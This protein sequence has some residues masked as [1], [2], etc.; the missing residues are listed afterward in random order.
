[1]NTCGS[2]IKKWRW[3]D[4]LGLTAA[5]ALLPSAAI[6]G[7]SDGR[8]EEM[9]SPVTAPTINEDPRITTEVRPMYMYTSISNSFVTNGGNYSV[10]AMQ[11]RAALTDRIGFIATKDGYIFLRPEK[12]LTAE[13]GFANLAFGFKG[14]LVKD[15]ANS[16]ILSTGIRWEAPTGAKK[17][18]QG[19]GDG[20][21]NPFLSVAK[22]IGP[23]NAQLYSGPRIAISGNDTTFWD[24]SFHLDYS[25]GGGFYPLMEFN[26]MRSLDGGRR[27]PIDQEGFDLVDI[28]SSKAN[29]KDVAT[30]ALGFRYR[31]L[32]NLDFGAAGEFPI[33]ER[34]DIFGWRVTTDL[35][36]R[37]FGW[38]SLL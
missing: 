32:D 16:F 37:P 1:M 36:W 23:V 25:A 2:R 4:W 5:V 9:I 30:M 35:I 28:G 31:I 11:L 10:V 33:T 13:D 3:R 34:E 6:A 21:L 12:T 17:V 14:A 22:G 29:G 26:W 24:S 20:L 19:K 18:L 38:S 27:L 7:A 15:E 8:I